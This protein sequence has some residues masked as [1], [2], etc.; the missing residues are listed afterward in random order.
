MNL[1]TEALRQGQG[2]I[3]MTL[4]DAARKRLAKLQAE[5]IAAQVKYVEAVGAMAAALGFA[6]P[7]S[8][9]PATGTL[10]GVQMGDAE[11]AGQE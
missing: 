1:M 2:N 4:P 8:Y 7:T 10:S 11:E 3:R 5:A 6:G 9:D